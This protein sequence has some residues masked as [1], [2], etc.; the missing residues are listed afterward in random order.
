MFLRRR[1]L[2]KL[3]LLGLIA[4]IT[5]LSVAVFGKLSQTVTIE[6]IDPVDF[7]KLNGDGAMPGDNLL[8]DDILHDNVNINLPHEPRQKPR[9]KP[10]P[11]VN[12]QIEVQNVANRAGLQEIRDNAVEEPVVVAHNDS[13]ADRER[14]SRRLIDEK[15]N[16]KNYDKIKDNGHMAKGLVIDTKKLGIREKELFDEGWSKYAFNE[17]ASTLIPINRTLPDIRL[18]GY[19][20]FS[21]NFKHFY[22]NFLIFIIKLICFKMQKRHLFTRLATG[23]SDYVL[24]Q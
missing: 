21:N 15:D 24:S 10:P 8:F 17:Y 20:F 11:P 2:Y 22:F 12:D 7:N 4:Y 3:M 9:R 19:E 5:Y 1:S 16:V 23:F 14:R 13:A 18:A 6:G